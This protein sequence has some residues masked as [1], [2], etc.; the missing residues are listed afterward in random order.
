[1]ADGAPDLPVLRNVIG[2]MFEA[3]YLVRAGEVPP[4]LAGD[5]GDG[6]VWDAGN[7]PEGG[8]YVLWPVLRGAFMNLESGEPVRQALPVPLEAQNSSHA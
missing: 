4:D 3:I 2:Q 5:N 7:L 1:M 8:G 6:I